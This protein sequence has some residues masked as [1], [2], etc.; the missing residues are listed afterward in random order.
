MKIYNIN[1]VAKALENKGFR[2]IK[3]FGNESE[4]TYIFEKSNSTTYGC[5]FA[6]VEEW[7]EDGSCTIDGLCP[8]EWGKKQLYN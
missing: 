1:Q 7:I 6:N 4:C 8:K 5:E 2:S 3:S